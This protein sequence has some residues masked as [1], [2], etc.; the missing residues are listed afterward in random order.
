[1]YLNQFTN[2]KKFWYAHCARTMTKRLQ[3]IY[4]TCVCA[5]WGE[6]VWGKRKGREY[7]QY[8][9]FFYKMTWDILF[10]TLS[11]SKM[12]STRYYNTKNVTVPQKTVFSPSLSFTAS[13]PLQNYLQVFK[14]IHPLLSIARTE[15]NW[16]KLSQA[17][18][19]GVFPLHGT[20]QIYSTFGNNV[21]AWN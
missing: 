5:C 1:M 16:A 8:F 4:V 11:A 20:V 17:K 6:G 12:S 2:T 3:W 21:S 9:F 7:L 10:H 14:Y 13:V 19:N 18:A 15:P